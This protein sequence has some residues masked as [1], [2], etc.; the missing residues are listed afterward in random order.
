MQLKKVITPK[1]SWYYLTEK[2]QKS[3]SFLRRKF[4][5][6]ELDLE[7]CLSDTE[8]PKLDVYDKYLF[9]VLFVPMYNKEDKRIISRG[10]RIFVG[11]DYL[12]TLHSGALKPLDK[13]F[14]EA[15][16]K[17]EKE[18]YFSKGPG[19][20]LYEIITQLY[21]YCF[22]IL[23]KVGANLNE[24]EKDLFVEEENTE[25]RDML[26]DIARIN[27]NIIVFRRIMLPQ[28][29]V[30]MRLEHSQL[31]FLPQ[32]WTVYFGDISDQIEKIW[33]I[34][35]SYKELIESLKDTNETLIS[36]RINNVMKILTIFSVTI[37]PLTF[38][39]GLYGMNVTLPFGNEPL[40]FWKL[41]GS[42]LALLA[43]MLLFF[44]RKRW[45]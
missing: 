18:Y 19:F 43:L 24:I 29:S 1:C 40:A 45:L 9:L 11:K 37:L 13:L 42:M 2:D 15:K 41:A 25:L 10:V 5:F 28:R 22:P 16:R 32:D 7:D 35:I 14:T 33:D 34:L 21:Q 27:R 36:H 44:K 39:T 3:I 23:D 26:R 38:I 12:V 30:I 31:E 8:R 6:H 4:K 20:L 17:N